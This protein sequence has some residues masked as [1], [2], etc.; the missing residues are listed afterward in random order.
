VTGVANTSYL[1]AV[2]VLW[3][4][5]AVF[6]DN[7]ERS[8]SVFGFSAEWLH[9]HGFKLA[10]PAVGR[11]RSACDLAPARSASSACVTTVVCC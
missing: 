5:P 11:F 10:E 9:E 1:C 2:T 4:R 8:V 7:D 3:S 6:Q